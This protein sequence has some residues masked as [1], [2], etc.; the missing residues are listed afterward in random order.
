MINGW[1]VNAYDKVNK[2]NGDMFGFRLDN[3]Y[4][5]SLSSIGMC[6][7]DY[8]FGWFEDYNEDMSI[9]TDWTGFYL[10]NRMI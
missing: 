7:S 3:F 9:D 2:V 4:D 8:R 6:I 5:G 10:N 1:V